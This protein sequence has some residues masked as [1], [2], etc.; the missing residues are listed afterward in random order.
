MTYSKHNESNVLYCGK[1]TKFSNSFEM[2]NLK[3]Y[4]INTFKF[5]SLGIV[6][7]IIFLMEIV[8]VGVC[9]GGFFKTSFKDYN[10]K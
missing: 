3:Q 7:K 5:C 4:S 8:C 6:S 10:Q 1:I 2:S 9:V